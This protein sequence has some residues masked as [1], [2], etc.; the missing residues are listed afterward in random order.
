MTGKTPDNLIVRLRDREHEAFNEMVRLCHAPVFRLAQRLLQNV[1]DA[2]EVAQET[3][4][5][6]YEGIEG[7]QGRSQIKTWLLAIAYR[8]T[9]DRLKKRIQERELFPE[10]MD[11]TEMWKITQNVDDF[12]DWGPNPEQY[13]N[14]NQISGILKEVLSKM[15]TESRAV[16]ELRDMQGFSSKEVSEILGVQE[17][18]IRVKLHR[19]RQFLMREMETLFGGKGKKP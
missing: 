13:V 19:V 18:T 7:F 1:D 14:R 5:A 17:G 3:F 15:P 4:L 10:T 12:T 11:E 16:F 2:Q 6:A 9:M 8:K